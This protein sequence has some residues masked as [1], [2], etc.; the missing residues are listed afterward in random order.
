MIAQADLIPQTCN[1]VDKTTEQNVTPIEYGKVVLLTY[2][3]FEEKKKHISIHVT[4][5]LTFFRVL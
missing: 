5:S 3:I 1:W 4:I 2:T